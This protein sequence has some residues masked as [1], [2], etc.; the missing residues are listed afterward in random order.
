MALGNKGKA[1]EDG[2]G[3][4]GSTRAVGGEGRADESARCARSVPDTVPQQSV[5]LDSSSNDSPSL[6]SA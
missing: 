5:M 3:Q 2:E 4:E 6:S 1:G